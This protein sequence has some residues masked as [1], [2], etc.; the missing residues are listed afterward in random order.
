[1]QKLR[2]GVLWR[3][4]A[5]DDVHRGD[6]YAAKRTEGSKSCRI[7]HQSLANRC[8]RSIVP[9]SRIQPPAWESGEVKSNAGKW[10]SFRVDLLGRIITTHSHSV[11][12]LE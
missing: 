1:M 5:V 11:Q 12:R 8:N 3:C 10:G 7:A 2:V 4:R 6:R 9:R